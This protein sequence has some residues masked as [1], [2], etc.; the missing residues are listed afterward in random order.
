MCITQLVVSYIVEIARSCGI[1]VFTANTD[2]IRIA[3]PLELT[4]K[5]FSEM[6]FRGEVEEEL[7]EC[8]SQLERQKFKADSDM[9][10]F[11]IQGQVAE[12]HPHVPT[13]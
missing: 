8:P 1:V 9:E 3:Y 5:H 6:Y 4:R 2:L 13:K 11:M 12:H 10:I 7:R